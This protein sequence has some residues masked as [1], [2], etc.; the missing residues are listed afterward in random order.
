MLLLAVALTIT[1][2][3]VLIWVSVAE[4]LGFNRWFR[5]MRRKGRDRVTRLSDSRKP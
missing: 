4:K 2:V 3:I 5:R 1:M